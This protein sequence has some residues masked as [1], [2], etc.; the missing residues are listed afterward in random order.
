TQD[1]THERAVCA[2]EN[3]S[4]Q[5]RRHTNTKD[6][7]RGRTRGGGRATLFGRT[8][9]NLR[10]IPQTPQTPNPTTSLKKTRTLPRRHPERIIPPGSQANGLIYTHK[11]HRNDPVN[12]YPHNKK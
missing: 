9:I 8:A 10:K 11:V 1:A 4:I 12:A 3:M 2:Q 5:D 6:C 7:E